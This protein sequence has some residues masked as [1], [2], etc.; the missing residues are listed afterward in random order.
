MKKRNLILLV[1]FTLAVLLVMVSAN[2]IIVGEKIGS[3]PGLAWLEY[4]FYALLVIGFLW[5]F[6]RPVVRVQM[7]PALPV[8]SV[9]KGE[10][11]EE[12]RKFARRLGSSFSYI[13][14]PK[15]RRER[16]DS[17][18]RR[19][20]K[21]GSSFPKLSEIVEQE[22]AV[23]FD[24]DSS[25]GV[26]GVDKRIRDWAKS[27]FMI[28]AVSQNS[29]VDTLGTVYMNYKMIED[30]VV[31][32]GFRPS[33]AQMF[34]VYRNVV[35]AAFV[36]FAVSEALSGAGSVAPFDFGDDAPD[37]VDAEPDFAPE[38]IA[39][40]DEEGFSFFSVM[41]RFR[42]PGVI[43]GSTIDGAANALMTLRLG[44]ITRS[45]LTEG[46]AVFRGIEGKRRVKRAAMRAA[47]RT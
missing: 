14:D 44:Y 34:K 6:V 11:H 7:A 21:Y 4:V 39:G 35:A 29:T 43:V 5:L 41:K 10:S 13:P 26:P 24:G 28:T 42:L 19:V 3:L 9:S 32:T 17:F 23:R 33:S 36:S 30:L 40:G 12:L 46:A 37:S 15:I 20:D 18:R 16:S 8:M 22:L 25:I 31:A 1:S 47:L 45:Y 38:D 2:V 27:V